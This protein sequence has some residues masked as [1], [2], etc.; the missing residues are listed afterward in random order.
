MKQRNNVWK[1]LIWIALLAVGMFLLGGCEKQ[2]QEDLL[3][4]HIF[5]VAKDYSKVEAVDYQTATD[6]SDTETL[7]QELM[8]QMMNPPEKR[9]N[10]IAPLGGQM[11]PNHFSLSDEK[12][13]LDFNESYKDLEVI[14]EVLYRSAIVR[15]L[16]QIEGVTVVTFS[17][18]GDALTDS[19]GNPIGAM[20]AESFINNAGNEISTYEKTKLHLYFANAAGDA[21]IEIDREVVYN[22]NISLER[23]VVEELIKGPNNDESYPTINPETSVLSVTTRDGVCYVNLSQAFLSQPYSVDSEVTIY[24]IVDSLSELTNINKVQ[25]SVEGETSVTYHDTIDLS[26]IFERN[27]DIVE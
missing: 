23:Q 21:L 2:A 9:V 1:K 3:T 13:N 8:I 11:H 5:Y 20:T 25:I 10:L 19:D 16:T 24:S 17:V 14:P 18:N 7:L 6:P 26:T 22:S 27:L 12:M 4:Y 15:T